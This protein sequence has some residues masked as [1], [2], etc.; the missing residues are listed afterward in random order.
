MHKYKQVTLETPFVKNVL[1]IYRSM[2]SDYSQSFHGPMER[3]MN[4]KPIF[5]S[6]TSSKLA[7]HP[8]II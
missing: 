3:V 4:M 8:Y 5:C 6:Q 7:L 1:T 2:P